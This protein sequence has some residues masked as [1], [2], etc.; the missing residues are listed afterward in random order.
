MTQQF[1]LLS[2]D[3]EEEEEEEKEKEALPA[4]PPAL[5]SP[6]LPHPRRVVGVG[7]TKG[8]SVSSN[9]DYCAGVLPFS[10]FNNTTYFL[11]GK[12]RRHSR[13]VSFSGKN[14]P[15][16]VDE[17]D[18]ASREFHEESLG[19][20][21]PRGPTLERVR[22]APIVLTSKTPRGKPCRTFVIPIPHSRC[23]VT[24][25][26]KTR[27]FLAEMRMRRYELC[28]MTD[29]KWVCARSLFT[30]IR[31]QWDEN[32]K[33]H[34]PSEWD[35]LMRFFHFSMV[36]ETMTSSMPTT[37]TWR[38]RLPPPPARAARVRLIVGPTCHVS[39]VI[40]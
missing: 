9:Y 39:V 26:H 30:R 27:R 20:I 17:C 11:L 2:T 18:T 3:G 4:L 40:S 6:S 23:Y 21:L 34:S 24:A 7:I 37:T 8:W 33:L 25:F 1:W 35:R 22:N 36:E 5:P 10:T 19:S 15:S 31:A 32:G 14:E 12:S 16:D 13:L 29:I 38:R 28:E